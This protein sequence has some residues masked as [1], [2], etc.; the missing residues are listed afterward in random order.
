MNKKLSVLFLLVCFI[1][2]LL[3]GCMYPEAEKVQNQTPYEVQ[4]Q[5]VQT[6]INQFQKDNGGILPIKNSVET[7]PNLSKVCD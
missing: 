6:A 7:T 2:V 1:I 4:M 5:S 3:S